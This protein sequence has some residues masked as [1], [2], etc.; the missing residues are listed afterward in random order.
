MERNTVSLTETT[1][2]RLLQLCADDGNLGREPDLD[3]AFSKF[4]LSSMDTVA[5]VAL[6]ET[7]FG[8]VIGPRDYLRL[9][10]LRDLVDFLEEES[11]AGASKPSSDVRAPG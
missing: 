9:T 6:V 3:L 5:F 2:N 10:T 4:G 8:V 11:Q 1:T 7:T